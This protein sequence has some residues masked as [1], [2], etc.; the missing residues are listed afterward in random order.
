M[1]FQ[2]NTKLTFFW[3]IGPYK[4][5]LVSR[6]YVLR[7]WAETNEGQGDALKFFQDEGV[8]IWNAWPEKIRKKLRKATIELINERSASDSEWARVVDSIKLFVQNEQTRWA[9]A[10]EERGDRFEG[11]KWPGWESIIQ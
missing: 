2:I 5:D 4:I 9:E 3:V 1:I 10:Y 6:A 8:T 7:S 11:A